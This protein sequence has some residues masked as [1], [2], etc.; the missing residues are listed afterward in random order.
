MAASTW[1]ADHLA[2]L[3]RQC[4]MASPAQRENC[5]GLC[6]NLPACY[7]HTLVRVQAICPPGC[8]SCTARPRH[9]TVQLRKLEVLEQLHEFIKRENEI[10]SITRQEAVS[11]VPPLFMD[12]QA[13]G[14][15]QGPG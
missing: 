4:R 8:S 5:H 2:Q 10:G 7:G 14:A 13:R 1:Q 15:M 12:V 3:L 11:M 6:S 9:C